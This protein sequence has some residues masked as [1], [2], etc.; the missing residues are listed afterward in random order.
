MLLLLNGP[1][2]AGKSTLARRWADERPLTLVV[3]VDGLRASL[4]GWQDTPASMVVARE[5][6]LALVRS[7]LTAG[8]D[9]VVPQYLGRLPF[10]SALADAAAS[11]GAEFVEV[12]L[13]VDAEVCVGRF[14]A[15]RA[16]LAAAGVVHPEADVPDDAVES[17]V[18]DAVARLAEVVAA[19][20]ATVVVDP[21]DLD[22][23]L[24]A[25]G[26]R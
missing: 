2:G 7:H 3:E 20:R 4:G 15:R 22:S 24:A 16:S 21:A 1:P 11:C 13:R 25:L 14:R 6:A 19:R 23:A 12:V 9:V 17:V 26:V 18:A 10:I 5:L 8:H